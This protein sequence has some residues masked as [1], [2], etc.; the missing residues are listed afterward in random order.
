MAARIVQ[1]VGLSLLM[2]RYFLLEISKAVKI[3]NVK[4]IKILTYIFVIQIQFKKTIYR[5]LQ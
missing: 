4:F 5:Y 3:S 2:F 1:F